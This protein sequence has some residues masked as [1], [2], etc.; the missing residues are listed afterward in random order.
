MTITRAP[1]GKSKFNSVNKDLSVEQF[2]ADPEMSSG[3]LG[4]SSD[5]ND[6]YNSRLTTRKM[7]AEKIVQAHI[8]W[9]IAAS[10]CP[11]P[12]LDLTIIATI[13]L[14]MIAKICNTY[15]LPFKR[16]A[17]KATIIT[18]LVGSI[19][20]IVTFNIVDIFKYIPVVGLVAS[21]TVS[22]AVAVAFTYSMGSIFI[23]HFEA[24]GTISSFDPKKK[25][26]EFNNQ[27]VKKLKS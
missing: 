14:S 16:N 18:L 26:V 7:Q 2:I 8:P 19:Q 1:R 15:E 27:F 9:V 17:A 4:S 3:L 12:I 11:L 10:G 22:S 5:E 6:I 21:F 13:Q 25:R 23:N 24:G 20:N